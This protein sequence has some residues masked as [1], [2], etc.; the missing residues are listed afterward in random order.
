MQMGLKSRE[1]RYALSIGTALIVFGLSVCSQGLAQTC[2]PAFRPGFGLPGAFL[3]TFREYVGDLE[4]WD[5][6]GAGP[7]VPQ[8]LVGGAFPIFSDT[9][10]NNFVA[11]TPSGWQPV[12]GGVNGRVD[13]VF[14]ASDNS[15]IIGGTFT[16]VGNAPALRVARWNGSSWNNFGPGLGRFSSDSI[17]DIVQTPAGTFAAGEFSGI[18]GVSGPVNNLA[19]WNGSIWQGVG[20]SPN[21]PVFDLEVL[22]S[23]SIVAVGDFSS[24]GGTPIENIA[25]WN[26]A[27]WSPVGTGLSVAGRGVRQLPGGDLLVWGDFTTAGG[28]SAQ[29]I[30]RWSSSLGWSPIGSGFDNGSVRDVLV[31]PNGDFIA[32]GS[33]TSA[34]GFPTDGIARWNGFSWLPV[35]G[36]ITQGEEFGETLLLEPTGDVLVAGNFRR[37]GVIDALSVARW[38][39]SVWSPI[40]N[41]F[42]ESTPGQRRT[43]QI[44]S[45]AEIPSPAGNQFVVGGTFTSVDGRVANNVATFDGTTWNTLTTPL[46]TGVLSDTFSSNVVYAVTVAPSGLIYVGGYFNTAGGLSSTYSV[47][48]WNGSTWSRLGTGLQN[49]GV[50]REEFV[51]GL[52]VAP[53]NIL[54]A[55]G[56]FL[57]AGGVPVQRVARW[58]G[59]NWNALGV[60]VNNNANCVLAI[61]NNDIL[62]GGAFTLAGNAPALRVARWN[63]TTWSPVGSGFENGE[64]LCLTQT[65]SGDILAGGTFTLANGVGVNRIA[66]WNGNAWLPLGQGLSSTVRSIIELPSG[67]I[68]AVGD[69]QAAGGAPSFYISRWN[70]AIWQQIGAGFSDIAQ[71]VQQLSNGDLLVGGQFQS[72]GTVVSG[73]LARF[74]QSGIPTIAAQPSPQ[75]AQAGSQAAF[76]STPASGLSN[77]AYAWRRNGIPISSGPGGASPGGGTVFNAFGT[78]AGTSQGLPATLIISGI[79]PSDQGQYSISFTNS[80]GTVLSPNVSLTVTSGSACRVDFDNSGTANVQ[81]IFLFLNEWFAGCP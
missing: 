71:V 17:Y 28:I 11:L 80:C 39:G 78:F 73:R 51:F 70:G 75:S 59:S 77:V 63:G 52:D 43:A 42:A 22:S 10:V 15:I 65:A 34:G 38:N 79:A 49:S 6:D 20:T 55:A 14:V 19:V 74:T 44:A 26:G 16:Q 61:A 21:G 50:F 76:S 62:F 4:R 9:F 18:G 30:A 67:E 25:I 66:R 64:V 68:L 1:P 37:A 57:N 32:T 31:M 5:P 3:P 2:D 45:I 29:R 23:G 72:S 27:T 47:A 60:G 8:L 54:Y 53:D 24:V 48:A 56:T 13:R 46:G 81:D 36:G 40:T 33:F 7:A 69:F 12:G 58:N 41:G 35:A